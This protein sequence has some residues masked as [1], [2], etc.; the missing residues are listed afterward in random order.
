MAKL[1]KI[2]EEEMNLAGVV[3]A[4]DTLSGS[5]AENKKLFDRMVRQLVA[6]AY[7]AAVDAI[8]E[9]EDTEAGIQAAEQQRQEN[10]LQRQENEQ[11]REDQESG[12]VAQAKNSAEDAQ[13]AATQARNNANAAASDASKASSSASGAATSMRQAESAANR[14]ASSASQADSRAMAAAKSE[15]R[16]EYSQTEAAKSQARAANAAEEAKAAATESKAAATESKTAAGKAEEAN[17]HQPRID[18]LSRNWELWDAETGEYV[19]TDYPAQGPRGTSWWDVTNDEH[20]S[21]LADVTVNWTSGEVYQSYQYGDLL[22]SAANGGVWEVTSTTGAASDPRGSITAT[23]RGTLK[24][25][26]TRTEKG[27]IRPGTDFDIAEDGTLSLYRKI[28]ITTFALNVPSIQE[29]GTV[30][31]GVEASWDYTREPEMQTLTLTG[32][33]FSTGF[34]PAKEVRTTAGL[35]EPKWENMSGHSAGFVKATLRGTDDHGREASREVSINWYNGVYTGARASGSI[36]SA[37]VLGL[38]KSLQGGRAKT[39]SVNAG[40]G[41]YIWYCCPVSY[42]TPNFNVGGFDGGFSKVKTFD[43]TNASGY[44]E[45]YQVWR[46]DNAGL[47]VTTVKVS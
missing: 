45:A 42:G 11:R 18:D 8:N 23:Y 34:S 5:A 20:F 38:S 24:P 17:R 31:N 19:L 47:G 2:T 4:P 40:A 30:V 27:L 13:S 9:M 43:F 12:Y 15:R 7:N 37:F 41:E 6:P 16:A 21:A 26:A 10:E 22:L 44:T 25:T 1:K 32:T 36:D 39:F 35:Q 46:S 29:V 14:A 28:A 3:A 33:D